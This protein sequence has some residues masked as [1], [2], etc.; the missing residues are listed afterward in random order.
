MLR[1]ETRQEVGLRTQ[2]KDV[3][4]GVVMPVFTYTDTETQRCMTY[5]ISL[6]KCLQ[7]GVPFC[8]G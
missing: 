4:E 8:K 3:N 2:R 1:I 7:N 6:D 5:S